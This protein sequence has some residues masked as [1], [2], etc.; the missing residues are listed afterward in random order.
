MRVVNK[1]YRNEECYVKVKVN[2]NRIHY[3]PEQIEKINS[4][5]LSGLAEVRWL[6]DE[7]AFALTHFAPEVGLIE[8]QLAQDPALGLDKDEAAYLSVKD[9]PDRPLIWIDDEVDSYVKK[10]K[11]KEFFASRE[12]T[13]IVQPQRFE[14]LQDGDLFDIEEFLKKFK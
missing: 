2:G 14:G 12:N 10:R 3:L 13:L 7:E 11:H 8:F 1:E 4:W 6:T 5:H 9:T